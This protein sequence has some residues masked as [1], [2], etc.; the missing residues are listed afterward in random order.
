MPL[1]VDAVAP[2]IGGNLGVTAIPIY[3]SFCNA[4]LRTRIAEIESIWHLSARD[5]EDD[6][7]LSASER[8]RIQTGRATVAR[9]QA[10]IERIRGYTES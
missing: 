3:R 10:R 9:Y 2:G 7:R 1:L 5:P 6:R 8:K 4:L